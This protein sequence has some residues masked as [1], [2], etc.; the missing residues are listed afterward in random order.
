VI[1]CFVAFRLL[2]FELWA[3]GFAVSHSATVTAFG[4]WTVIAY[5]ALLVA[6]KTFDH[7]AVFSCVTRFDVAY[8]DIS[9][10]SLEYVTRKANRDPGSVLRVSRAHTWACRCPGGLISALTMASSGGFST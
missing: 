2:Q 4:V 6:A 7:R 3:L 5:M 10:A 9:T 1:H 8:D